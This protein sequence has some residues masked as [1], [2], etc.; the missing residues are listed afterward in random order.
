MRNEI[1][2]L[3][4]L[5]SDILDYARPVQLQREKFDINDFL[6][7]LAEFY[8]GIFDEKKVTVKMD[9]PGGKILVDGD[10]D[11]LRQ[12]FVNLIQNAIEAMPT[13]GSLSLK[14]EKQQAM[15]FCQVRDTGIGISESALRRLFDLFFTTKER[16][17]GLGLSNVRKIIDAHGGRIEI[18][19]YPQKG[20]KVNLWLPA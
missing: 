5:V 18:D 16:G 10:K 13:G 7:K 17:T 12:A 20:T 4:R 6:K 1:G 3:D 14:V 19:S 9:L 15:I 2:R 11:K 8:K